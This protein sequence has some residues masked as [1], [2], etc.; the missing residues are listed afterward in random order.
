MENS[1][2]KKRKKEFFESLP[3]SVTGPK[4]DKEYPL[5]NVE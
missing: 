1:D 5:K 2:L 4:G 3:E